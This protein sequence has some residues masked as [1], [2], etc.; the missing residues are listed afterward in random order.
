MRA[1]TKVPAGNSCL[2]AG[3][4]VTVIRGRGRAYMTCPTCGKHIYFGTVNPKTAEGKAIRNH[5]VPR[6]LPKKSLAK[7]SLKIGGSGRWD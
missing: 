3:R 1:K 7:M 2:G 6:H 5:V 4:R